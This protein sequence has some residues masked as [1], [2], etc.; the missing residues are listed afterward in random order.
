MN[1][2]NFLLISAAAAVHPPESLIYPVPPLARKN[3]ARRTIDFAQNEKILKFLI[4]GGLPNVIYGGNA[5][6]YD[7]T[8]AEY[9]DLLEWAGGFASR[10]SI[11]P[12][13][14]PSYGCAMDQAT[15]IRRYKFHTVLA[16]PNGNPRDAAGL[17]AGYREISQACGL[18]LSLYVKTDTTYG[19]DRDA[20]LDA[21]GRLVRDGVCV[22]IKYAV[23]R[24]DPAQDPYLTALLKCIDSKYVVSG[25]GERPA[26]VHLRDFKLNGFTTGSGVLAPNQTRALLDACNRGDYETAER[27]RQLF[28]PLEDLRDA[29]GPPRVLH[30]AV[31][32]S[33]LAET[34]SPPP[35]VS[36]LTEAQR[37][38]LAPVARALFGS[39]GGA[40][41]RAC[42]VATPRDARQVNHT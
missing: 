27:V 41:T 21:I 8:M 5:F 18:P 6:L 11:N 28:L 34:G 35:F 1:R 26:I 3:D 29:W 10:A 4:A 7:I 31:G 22:S 19:D 23:V 12:A 38:Q 15:V 40:R 42:R 32:L 36:N 17:E 25:I 9:R 2:R 14:G 33:G 24:K 20:G 39:L 30:A 13:I 37:K 16:M